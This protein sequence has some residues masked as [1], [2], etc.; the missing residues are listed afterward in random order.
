MKS[1]KL[2]GSR[3]HDG[4]VPDVNWNRYNDKLNVNW[5]NSDNANDN[6]RSRQKFPRFK[7]EIPL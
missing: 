5:Y 2:S 3:Y 6:L 4:N 1:D 7:Q